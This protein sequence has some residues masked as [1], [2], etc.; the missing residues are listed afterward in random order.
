MKLSRSKGYPYI[1]NSYNTSSLHSSTVV[2][3]LFSDYGECIQLGGT[4]LQTL[5]ASKGLIVLEERYGVD[6]QGLNKRLAGY[7]C[8]GVR[9][10]LFSLF[11]FFLSYYFL[12]CKI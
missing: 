3:K 5:S 7:R 6:E 10:R 1:D 9:S 11:F 2:T 8:N 12:R 4:I